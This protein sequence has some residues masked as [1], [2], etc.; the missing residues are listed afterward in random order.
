MR[1]ATLKASVMSE[2][3]KARAI[4]ISRT[5][6]VMRESIVRLLMVA[7]ALSRFKMRIRGSVRPACGL[8]RGGK[9]V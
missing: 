2:A 1:N 9:R 8:R 7:S 4:R 6:P 5:R 3:P